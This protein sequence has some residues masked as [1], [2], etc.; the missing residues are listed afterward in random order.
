MVKVGLWVIA[1]IS[2]WVRVAVWSVSRLG[3]RLELG[4]VLRLGRLELGL[5]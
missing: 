2:V 1:K 4:L 5:D 3:L